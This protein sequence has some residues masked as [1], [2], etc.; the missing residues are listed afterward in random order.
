MATAM[1]VLQVVLFLA[2]PLAAVV[3]EKRL[4]VVRWLNP[5]LISYAAGIAMANLPFFEVS[6]ATAK[7][8][9]EAAIPLAVPLILFGS[10]F[11]AWLRRSRS[12]VISFLLAVFAAFVAAFGAERLL[13]GL[14]A[15]AW[16]ISPMLVGCYTG[17]T[18]NLM[19]IGMALGARDDTFILLNAADAV[20][21]GTWLLVLLTVAKPLFSKIFPPYPEA[22]DGAEPAS[23]LAADGGGDPASPG[24]TVRGMILAF[25][26]SVAIVALSAG[27]T[28]LLAGSVAVAGVFLG[29]TTGGV[30]GSFFPKVRALPGSYELGQYLILVFCVAIGARTDL[31]D[32]LA[33]GTSILAYTAAVM[34]TAIVLHALLARLFRI[35][36]DTFIITSTAAV[37]GP[38]FV[39]PTAEAIGNRRV[40]LSGLTAGLVGYAIGNYAGLLLAWLV[41]P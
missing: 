26:L 40:I 1:I 18:P 41:H 11:G 20:V 28:W 4:K 29:L 17:G 13:G 14:S 19:S 22:D 36:V 12:T 5:V 34:F 7:T 9:S 30:V 3:G 37:Y 31:S 25:L 15:E 24:P 23:A 33:H 16:K 39:V 21:G 8:V 27:L 32:L 35:D 38:A 2:I 10:D 6:E